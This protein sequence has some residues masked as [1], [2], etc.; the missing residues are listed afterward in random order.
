[1]EP[2]KETGKP[3]RKYVWT[4]DYDGKRRETYGG[5]LTENLVQAVSRDVFG[6]QLV[7][8]EDHGLPALFSVHD[9]AVLECDASVTA[10][11]IEHEMSHC[12]D[13][14]AGCPIGAEAKEV[15]CYIK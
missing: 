1:V 14:L 11:D 4:C 15:S 2:D 3:R 6:E 10:K 9:E 13:W 7:R 5:K 8:M 12:P